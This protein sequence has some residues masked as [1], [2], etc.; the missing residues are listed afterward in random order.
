MGSAV[1]EPQAPWPRS[2]SKSLWAWGCLSSV[3]KKEQKIARKRRVEGYFRHR[4]H[5]IQRFGG[6]KELTMETEKEQL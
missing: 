4:G 3:L 5:D 2:V 1:V 6:S